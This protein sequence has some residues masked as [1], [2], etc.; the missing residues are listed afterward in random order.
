MA[1][2]GNTY[3]VDPETILEDTL[4]KPIIAIHQGFISDITELPANIQNLTGSIGGN[5]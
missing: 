5:N 1:E 2:N 3:G 4:L